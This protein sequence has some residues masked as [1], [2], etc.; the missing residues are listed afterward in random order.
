MKNNSEV[1][2]YIFPEGPSVDKE[3]YTFKSMMS[4]FLILNMMIPL[5]LAVIIIIS[6]LMLT[7]V[8]QNDSEFISEE[9][10]FREKMV[11]GCD[12]KNLEMHEDLAK[13]KHIFC[14][15]TGTLTKNLL[16]FDC[17]ALADQIFEAERDPNLE[18]F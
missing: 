14:D 6:K 8:I 15:K 10:S 11:V 5:D 3:E 4:F 13:I 12:V 7:Y 16:V 18:R 9:V 17:F 2:T 1:H